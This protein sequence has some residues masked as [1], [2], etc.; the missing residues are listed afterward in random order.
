MV[1]HNMDIVNINNIDLMAEGKQFD[2]QR[3]DITGSLPIQPAESTKEGSK[4]SEIWIQTAECLVVK[5]GTQQIR[6]QDQEQFRL[7][8]P[9]LAEKVESLLW[10]VDPDGP[11]GGDDQAIFDWSWIGDDNVLMCSRTFLPVAELLFIKDQI[12]GE[13]CRHAGDD[14][15]NFSFDLKAPF[16]FEVLKQAG[17]I[18]ADSILMNE[19]ERPVGY[20]GEFEAA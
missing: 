17:S 9:M 13:V 19:D 5:Q 8:D 10:Y 18:P 14:W 6:R 4:R 7:F 11:H 16:A 3:A 20:V 12:L 1:K 2:S 15:I